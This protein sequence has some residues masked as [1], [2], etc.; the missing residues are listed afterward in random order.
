MQSK[1]RGIRKPSATHRAMVSKSLLTGRAQVSSVPRSGPVG[2]GA[3]SP[4]LYPYDCSRR[5]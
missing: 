1:G 2:V 3:K 4:N 5:A